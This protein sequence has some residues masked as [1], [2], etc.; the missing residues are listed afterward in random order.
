MVGYD[1]HSET[2]RVFVGNE[3]LTTLNRRKIQSVPMGNLGGA[4]YMFV[5]IFGP[6]SKI[7]SSTAYMQRRLMAMK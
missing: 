5:E 7:K 4:A 3:E 6:F 1:R 2:E